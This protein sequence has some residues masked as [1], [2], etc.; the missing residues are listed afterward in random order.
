MARC[1]HSVKEYSWYWEYEIE[2]ISAEA[3]HFRVGVLRGEGTSLEAPVG[4]DENS[5]GYRDLLGSKVH[6]SVRHYYGEPYGTQLRCF[7]Q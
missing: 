1:T 3:A 7:E 2:T 5:W 6:R 4:F